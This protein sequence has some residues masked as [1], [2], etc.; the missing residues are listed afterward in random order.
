[1]SQIGTGTGC[2]DECVLLND[3]NQH[4]LTQLS[5]FSLVIFKYCF[6]KYQNLGLEL[7]GETLL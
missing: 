3:L 7:S 6:I 2:L 1:M 4:L 5:K